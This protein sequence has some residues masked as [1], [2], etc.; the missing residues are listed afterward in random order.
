MSSNKIISV[1]NL[2]SVYN[3]NEDNQYVAL[4]NI[5]FDFEQNK[6]YF[7]IGNSGSGK[8]TLVTHFNG[9]INT[10][11][12]QIDIYP[13]S[14]KIN[15]ET[16]NLIDGILSNEIS[17]EFL[18]SKFDDIVALN[19]KHLSLK[20]IKTLLQIISKQKITKIQRNKLINKSLD[21]KDKC[22][23]NVKW[24]NKNESNLKVINDFKEINFNN[25]LNKIPKEIKNNIKYNEMINLGFN[26]NIDDVLISALDKS[27]IQ[28]FS[29]NKSSEIIFF[30]T[31]KISKKIARILIEGFYKVKVSSIK[32]INDLNLMLNK[33]KN[34][35]AFEITLEKEPSI[36]IIDRLSI[37]KIREIKISKSIKV[38]N[39]LQKAQIKKIK[40]FRQLRR[41]IGMV[42]QF[43]EYQLFKDTIEKDIM[44][45]PI[46][47][48][49]KKEE[50]KRRAKLYLNK[51]SMG[52]EY[53][54]R[55]PFG[56]SGGQKRRVAIAGILAIE[57]DVLIFDEP[58]A[59]LDPVGEQETM[60]MIKEIQQTGKTIFVI[61]HTMDHVLEVA[62]EVLVL[63]DGEI[64]KHGDPY[65]IF[66]DEE[67]ITSTSIDTPKVIKTIKAL[68][69]KDKRFEK[70]ID[71]K[72]KTIDELNNA[73][74]D[75]IQNI[76]KGESHVSRE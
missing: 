23:V 39:I 74:I 18:N 73:I 62:D 30:N 71:Y 60:K 20:M 63:N 1:N 26:W 52:D 24:E 13:D 76:K 3:E 19:T 11:Y 15:K 33:L 64:I 72:P 31:S 12:G 55:N 66:L 75:L 35:S 54:P 7:I 47:L 50:A 58:T 48:G 45:G 21:N 41:E 2:F 40:N 44:F 38:P 6:I 37:E 36:E 67:I 25:L 28:K 14:K 68:I 59:G 27:E 61:T 22:F 17:N 4:S 57:T 65:S 16:L 5:N 9:L 46:A 56:L 51:L 70:L 49:I 34:K 10:K 32:R 8:S 53:L 43:P 42:F 69:K 29:K